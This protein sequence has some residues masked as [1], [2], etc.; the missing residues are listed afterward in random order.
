MKY[1]T[2]QNNAKSLRSLTGLSPEQ[3]KELLPYFTDGSE[4]LQQFYPC[5]IRY[6]AEP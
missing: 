2:H 4:A 3:F 6:Q 5:P 1:T